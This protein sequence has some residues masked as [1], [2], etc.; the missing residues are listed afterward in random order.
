MLLKSYRKEIFRPECNPNFQTLHCIAHLDQ[1]IGKVLPYLNS[2]LGGFE[3]IN[4]PP[5][6]TFKVHGKLITV[7]GNKIAVNALKD[8]LEAENILDGSSERSMKHGISLNYGASISSPACLLKIK[9]RLNLLFRNQLASWPV[10]FGSWIHSS[11]RHNQ[12]FYTE[13]YACPAGL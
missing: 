1:D 9:P 10:V 7:H 4:D 6:L 12:V 5:S 8:D 3:Y 13:I 11:Y 2:T